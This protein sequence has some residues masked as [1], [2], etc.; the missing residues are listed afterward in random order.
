MKTTL[1]DWVV[2]F[3]P[4][5]HENGENGLYWMFHWLNYSN[6]LKFSIWLIIQFIC[7]FIYDNVK[8]ST[9]SII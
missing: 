2:K 8:K 4:K 3:F 6:I 5:T 1:F 7:S 9:F